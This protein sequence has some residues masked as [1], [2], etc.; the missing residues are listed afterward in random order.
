MRYSHTIHPFRVTFFSLYSFCDHYQILDHF[1]HLK[2]N[3]M[4]FAYYP[5]KAPTFPSTNNLAY[6]LSYCDHFLQIESCSK[7]ILCVWSPHTDVYI[8][9]RI[10]CSY[11]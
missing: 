9:F 11:K 6:K 3:S 2:N 8:Y 5:P 10:W 7:E 1:H 4:S